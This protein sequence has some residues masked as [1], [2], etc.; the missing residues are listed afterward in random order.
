LENHDLIHFLETI[1]EEL[2]KHAGPDET[3]EFHLHGIRRRL[4]RR[5]SHNALN[6][7]PSQSPRLDHTDDD[8]T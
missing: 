8:V 1:D 5:P 3:V 4:S 6:H 7:A 2:V